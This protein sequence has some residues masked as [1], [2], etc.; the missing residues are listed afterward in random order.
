MGEELDPR[1]ADAA[2]RLRGVWKSVQH[3]PSHLA[4]DE[5]A[6]YIAKG[7]YWDWGQGTRRWRYPCIVAVTDRRVIV[8][9]RWFGS[10]RLVSRGLREITRIDVGGGPGPGS[11]TIHG[12]DEPVKVTWI[13]RH[14]ARRIADL[15]RGAPPLPARRQAPPPPPPR[16][17]PPSRG[18]PPPPPGRTPPQGWA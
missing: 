16:P 3:L 13:R 1:I 8:F 10:H 9:V 11:L 18:R 6:A 15:V 4:R 17:Q 5:T 2:S 14:D 12:G 7:T